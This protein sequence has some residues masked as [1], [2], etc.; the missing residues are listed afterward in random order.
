[1][2]GASAVLLFWITRTIMLAHRGGM[3]DDPIVYAVKD[4]TS[5]LCAAIILTFVLLGSSA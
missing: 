2:W 1:L 5:Q 4:R 3:H